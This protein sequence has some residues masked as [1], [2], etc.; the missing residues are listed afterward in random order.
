M[1]Y[2]PLYN[3]NNLLQDYKQILEGITDG[4]F[5]LDEQ[6]CFTY[7]NKAAEEGAGY[8]R[9]DVLGKNVFEIF[10]N[11]KDAELGEKYRAAMESKIPQSCVSSYKDDR[12]DLFFDVR[13]FPMENGIVVFFHDIS[14]EQR[15]R[16]QQQALIAVSHALNNAESFEQLCADAGKSIAAF[17]EIP[18][19]FVC[20]YRFEHSSSVLHLVAPNTEA[21]MQANIPLHLPVALQFDEK[22]ILQNISDSL[23]GNEQPESLPQQAAREHTPIVTDILLRGTLTEK[24]L[25]DVEILGM[26]SLVVLPL[27]VQGELQGVLEA[28]TKKDVDFVN[29]ELHILTLIANELA[30]GMS[31]KRLMEEVMH[32]KMQ[33]ELEAQKTAEANTTLKRFLAMFSHDLRAP[34]A[35]IVGF[36][37]LLANDLPTMEQAQVQDFMKSIIVSGKH[38]QHLIDDIL[39]LSKIEAGTMELHRMN[40]PATHFTETLQRILQ[41]KLSE[42]NIALHYQL[43]SDLDVLF[44]DQT[45]FQQILV[46]LTT[47][48]IKY[49]HENGM[50]TIAMSREEN[51]MLV[52]VR[53]EGKGIPREEIGKLF[54]PFHQVRGTQKEGT[55]LGLAITKRLVELHGG[56]IWVESEEGISTVFSLR[57]PIL[58][59]TDATI[60]HDDEIMLSKLLADFSAKYH[61]AMDETG[62]QRKPLALLVEDNNDSLQILQN[63]FHSAGFQT[64]CARN[65]AEA[66]E[67]AKEFHPDVITL[68]VYLP[69]RNG[70]TVLKELKE[71][72]S[73][74]D[75]PVII[76]SVSDQ[77]TLGFTLGA[78]EYFVKPV[79][80]EELLAAVKRAMLSSV[81]TSHTSKVLLIDDD[82]NFAELIDVMLHN[83]GLSVMRGETGKQGL[84]L[85]ETEHPDLIILDMMLP[86][87]TGIEVAHALY[88][89]P[90]TREIPII[91]LT[92]LDIDDELRE[93]LYGVV[94]NVMSKN[95]FTKKDVLREIGAS[96]RKR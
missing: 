69:V 39:D 25:S 28:L 23:N 16:Q 92:S 57:I 60:R 84:R 13:I 8:V 17:L 22:K 33:V 94:R 59:S 41:A 76:V 19:Q 90:M 12:V 89:N 88:E 1:I 96:E 67:M 15:Q 75:I 78:A 63:Y 5:A 77:R 56:K 36:S 37:E 24:F 46:N 54:Q 29:E 45:R 83:E 86:D 6:Y 47:N 42:K 7:W 3:S 34:L 85:A 91:V 18:S 58:V 74:K 68:D 32:Q 44:V 64:E 72:P 43:S 14:E 70:W 27:I 9:E 95:S 48:A 4:F 11:A 49:S 51:D 93:N 38:L 50:I 73:L 62:I 87:T 66:M 2:S 80:K 71:H 52:S 79:V 81:Q 55:G 53:D 20:I 35:S 61:P 40:Y 65:G 30:T 82:D 21:V 26:K 31:R 10:P